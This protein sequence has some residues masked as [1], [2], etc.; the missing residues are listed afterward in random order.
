MQLELRHV[1]IK[2]RTL[3]NEMKT[4][5]ICTSSVSC[6]IDDIVRRATGG[7]FDGI[8]IDIKFTPSRRRSTII[9]LT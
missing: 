4:C 2:V 1:L 8:N 6:G 3:L 7:E 5:R 9:L